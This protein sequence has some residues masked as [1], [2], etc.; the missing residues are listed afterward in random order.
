MSFMNEVSDKFLISKRK[1]QTRQSLSFYPRER[2]V[3]FYASSFK[4]TT[5]DEEQL[6][7]VMVV[8][9]VLLG[10]AKQRLHL[11]PRLLAAFA[12]GGFFGGLARFDL[13]AREFPE[14]G[15]GHAGG[16]LAD[17]EL[18]FVLDDGDGDGRGHP[19]IAAIGRRG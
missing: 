17:E 18:A 19:A 15:Q 7:V 3:R 12:D 11:N 1:T 9:V 2:R 6:N 8:V 16:P 14:A 5:G 4:G 13:A 10:I